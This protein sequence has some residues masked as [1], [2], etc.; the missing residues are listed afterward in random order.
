VARLVKP[1]V[2][3]Y[4]IEAEIIHEYISKRAAGHSFYPIV[5]SGANAC[6]LHYM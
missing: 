5:A 6:V 2:A 4:E 3:E 1:G